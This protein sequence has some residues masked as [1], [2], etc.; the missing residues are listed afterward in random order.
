LDDL[1]F[2]FKMTVY[3][4]PYNNERVMNEAAGIVQAILPLL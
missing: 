1:H 3:F 2:A 4:R